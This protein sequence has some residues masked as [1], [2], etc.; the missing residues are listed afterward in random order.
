MNKIL[1]QL[2]ALNPE[3]EELFPFI[4]SE[5]DDINQKHK[6]AAD[7]PFFSNTDTVLITYP[8]QFYGE[9]KN[10]LQYLKDFITHDLKGCISHTHILPFYPWTSDDGFS[11]KNYHEVEPEYGTWQDIENLPCHTMFDCV[12]NHLSS[13]SEYFK[14]ARAGDKAKQEMFHI[15]DEKTFNTPEFQENIPKV[16]RPRISSLF[17]EYDFKGEKKYAW[18]TFSADQ[19]DTN[20][21]NKDMFKYILES[22]FLYINKGARYFR[23]DAVPFLWKQL[24]TNCSHLEK[25][26]LVIKLFRSIVDKINLN[27]IIIT[28]SNVPHHENITYFGNGYDEAHMVYN[29]S[30]A[31]LLLHALVYQK[32][33]YI[34]DWAKKVFHTTPKSTFLNFTATHDGIGMRGIEGLVPEEDI[35]ELCTLTEQKGGKVGLKRSRDGS[36]KPY[37]LNITWASILNDDELSEEDLVRKI[38]NSHAVIMF[39]PGIG[40]HYVHNFFGTQNWQEGF[41]KS[42]IARRLNRKKLKYPIEHSS[43]SK[44]VLEGLREWIDFKSQYPQISPNSYFEVIDLDSRVL[45]FQRG[46]GDSKLLLFF[47]LSD[48]KLKIKELDTALKPF[49]LLIL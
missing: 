29:F 24:G 28:E 31:P 20:L 14:Q 17:T 32:N 43:F 45:S 48:K 27:L 33:E 19:I 37:E 11:P 1:Q 22:F 13:E 36:V 34:H 6:E 35:K 38:V 16:V 41:K 42:G 15:Y 30:L 40:A 21:N 26:H 46:E 10:N 8:D 7:A 25:T 2:K 9:D 18:T 12:F 44:K 39:F 4:Q 23:I 47:N 5:I 49:E 3:F